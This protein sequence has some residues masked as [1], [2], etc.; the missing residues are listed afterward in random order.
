MRIMVEWQLLCRMV[1]CSVASEGDIRKKLI[2]FNLLDAAIDYQQTFLWYKYSVC[3]LVKNP[4]QEEMCYLSMHL[5]NLNKEKS[6]QIKTSR[7]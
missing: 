2:D 4:E 1:F 6:K 7:Y 3:I 5:R